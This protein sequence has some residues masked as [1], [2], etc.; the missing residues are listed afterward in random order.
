MFMN[1]KKGNS[2]NKK[3]KD[4]SK[5]YNDYIG[6][7]HDEHLNPSSLDE[8][9]EESEKEEE[10]EYKPEVR[11]KEISDPEFLEDWQKL[12]VNFECFEDYAEFMSKMDLKPTPK[13]KEIIYTTPGISTGVENFFSDED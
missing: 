2:M 5:T 8:F 7:I 10:K 11:K 9:L 6:W 12:W 1:L 4:T 13:L 3:V